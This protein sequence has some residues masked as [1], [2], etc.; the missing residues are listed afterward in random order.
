MKDNLT[1]LK[2]ES[3]TE[4]YCLPGDRR[5]AAGI[6]SNMFMWADAVRLAELEIYS[7]TFGNSGGWAQTVDDEVKRLWTPT[8]F[9]AVNS[10]TAFPFV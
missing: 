2:F 5:G 7:Q 3:V 4:D 10:L 8:L 6:D 9:Q 1:Y